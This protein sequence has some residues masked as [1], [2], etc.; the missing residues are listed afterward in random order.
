MWAALGLLSVFA[1]VLCFFGLFVSIIERKLGFSLGLLLV[2]IGCIGFCSYAYSRQNVEEMDKL[3]SKCFFEL[4]GKKVIWNVSTGVATI[5]ANGA[6]MILNVSDFKIKFNNEVHMPAT[7][8]N[9][10]KRDR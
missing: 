3:K 9:C 4:D 8:V 7:M 6:E 1:G 2:I 5:N 10:F